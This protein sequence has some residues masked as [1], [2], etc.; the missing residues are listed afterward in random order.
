[1]QSFKSGIRHILMEKQEYEKAVRWHLAATKIKQP[2]TAML[3]NPA[4]YNWIPYFQ[5]GICYSYLGDYRKACHY[6]ELAAKYIPENP[7]VVYNLQ[8]FNTLL[9]SKE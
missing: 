6:N 8:Y 1:M 5:I 3:Y 2:T 7:A 4:S 9:Q